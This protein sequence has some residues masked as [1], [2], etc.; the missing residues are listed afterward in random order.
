MEAVNDFNL[1]SLSRSCE[2]EIEEVYSNWKKAVMS[3]DFGF[4][5]NLYSDNFTSTSPAGIIKNKSEVLTRLRF[6]DLRYLF[7]ED[8]NVLID[9]KG[10]NAI[11]K[12]R[13]TLNIELYNLPIKIDRE[14]MLTFVKPVNEWLLQNIK[15]TSI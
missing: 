10:E 3:N 8:K 9:I 11:L 6:K 7:W 5:E 13:Q 15:E 14:I 2:K 4:L 1:Y 12:S